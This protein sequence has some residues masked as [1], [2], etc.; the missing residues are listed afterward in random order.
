VPELPCPTVDAAMVGRLIDF[1]VRDA[2]GR[3]RR[4]RPVAGVASS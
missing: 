3:G 2:W 1:A 4:R